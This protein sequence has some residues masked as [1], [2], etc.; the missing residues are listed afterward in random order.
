MKKAQISPSFPLESQVFPMIFKL[1]KTLK[2]A[3][4][5]CPFVFFQP[6]SKMPHL[7]F[8]Y[9]EN[10]TKTRSCEVLSPIARQLASH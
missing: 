2:Y 1:F 3:L 7:P 10:L 4:E 6:S 9:A 8:L 5:V